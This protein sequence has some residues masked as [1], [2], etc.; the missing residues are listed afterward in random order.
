MKRCTKD[1]DQLLEATKENEIESQEAIRL[2]HI[3]IDA[4]LDSTQDV[5]KS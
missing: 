3:D 4:L 1:I 5:K 2:F